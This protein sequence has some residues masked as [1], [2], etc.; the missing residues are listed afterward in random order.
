SRRESEA[1]DI[2]HDLLLNGHPSSRARIL[3]HLHGR[4]LPEPIADLL[5][6]LAEDSDPLIAQ[7]ATSLIADNR[8]LETD[9]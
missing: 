7:S 2:R 1:D 9:A 3:E 5:P 4:P 6:S 8:A